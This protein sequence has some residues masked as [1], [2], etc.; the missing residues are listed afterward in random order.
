M[1]PFEAQPLQPNN[2]TERLQA[3]A[4][5]REAAQAGIP[6]E[7]AL[8]IKTNPYPTRSEL[9]MGLFV[10]ELDPPSGRRWLS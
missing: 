3:F 9:E 6:E 1:I 7:V 10:E 2:E 5:L 8:R 4:T